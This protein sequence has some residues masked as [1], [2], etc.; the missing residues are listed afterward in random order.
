MRTLL[1]PR[2]LLLVCMTD[3]LDLAT[4]ITPDLPDYL[5]PILDLRVHQSVL[6]RR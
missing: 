2:G 1:R 3:T 6:T 4:M 5:R